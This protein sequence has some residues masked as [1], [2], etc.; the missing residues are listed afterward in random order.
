MILVVQP[1]IAYRRG[2]PDDCAVP[3]EGYLFL[4]VIVEVDDDVSKEA[5]FQFLKQRL[6]PADEIVL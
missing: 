3:P 6:V 5:L 4:P 1:D 2:L